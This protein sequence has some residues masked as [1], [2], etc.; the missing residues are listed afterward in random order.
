[1][2]AFETDLDITGERSLHRLLDCAVTKEGSER[3]KSWLLSV[4][5]DADLISQRQALVCELKDHYTFRDKLQLLS[6]VARLDTGRRRTPSLW[7]SQILVDWIGRDERKDS[8][9]PTV[10]MLSM[11]SAVNII[12]VVL[13]SLQVIPPIWPITFVIY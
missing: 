12:C 8:L 2:H 6:D 3:L 10:V 1:G 4:R 13:A 5:P 7:N 9:L 11:L